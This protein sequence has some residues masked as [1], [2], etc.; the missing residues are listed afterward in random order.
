MTLPGISLWLVSKWRINPRILPIDLQ[1]LSVAWNLFL[2]AL[3]SCSPL[4]TPRSLLGI[5]NERSVK[6]RQPT[7]CVFGYLMLV[8]LFYLVYPEDRQFQ[9]NNLFGWTLMLVPGGREVAMILGGNLS[10]LQHQLEAANQEWLVVRRCADG[11]SQS[12][13]HSISP[14]WQSERLAF[15]RWHCWHWYWHLFSF[16]RNPAK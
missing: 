10:S 6:P 12:F 13:Q 16:Q 4:I 7:F 14:E 11:V 2:K 8:S 5:S 3:F 15:S 1:P 9:D